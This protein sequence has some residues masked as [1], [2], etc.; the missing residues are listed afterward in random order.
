MAEKKHSETLAVMFIDIVDYTKTTSKLTRENVHKLQEVFDELSLP[1]FKK[2]EGNVIKKIGDAF[3]ITFKSPTNALLCG[4]ELQNDFRKFNRRKK[5]PIKIRVGIHTGEVVIKGSDVYGDAVNTAARVQSAAHAGHIVF[6]GAVYLVI[7][8]NEIPSIHLGT[9]KLKG[10]RTAIRL[11]RVKTK[12]DE[13]LRKR[14]KMMRKLKK[15]RNRVFDI[16]ILVLLI[17]F[18]LFG[19]G[20]LIRF[21]IDFL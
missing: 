18:I 19:F 7:N 21:L 9:K 20:A 3:L 4:I 17:V 6:S 1:N 5:N 16:I 10:L 2:Y 14:K 11:F 13:I 12:Y 8:K 15:A